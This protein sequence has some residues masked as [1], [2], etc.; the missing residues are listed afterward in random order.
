MAAWW[1]R[2]P[3]RWDPGN[4]ATCDIIVQVP[5]CRISHRAAMHWAGVSRRRDRGGSG[6]DPLGPSGI[7]GFFPTWANVLGC[8]KGSLAKGP[9]TPHRSTHK[10]RLQAPPRWHH[11]LKLWSAVLVGWLE[12][13]A[14]SFPRSETQLI[15][16]AQGAFRRWSLPQAPRVMQAGDQKPPELVKP[17]RKR[18][19]KELHQQE[20][21]E[22]YKRL[23]E[24]YRQAGWEIIFPDGSHGSSAHH[25]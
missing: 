2:M 23:I 14:P 25:P 24:R 4:C 22:Y 9:R 11:F 15:V 16:Q 19:R 6:G 10:F 12:H 3:A 1:H 7:V 17:Q 5:E 21:C 13:L 20:L 8:S 18:R